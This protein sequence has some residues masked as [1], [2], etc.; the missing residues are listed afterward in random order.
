MITCNT[1]SGRLAR[2]YLLFE[3]IHYSINVLTIKLDSRKL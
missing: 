3:I 1:I 2:L